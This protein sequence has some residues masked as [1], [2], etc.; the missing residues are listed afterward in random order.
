MKNNYKFIL[1]ITSLTAGSILL[2]QAFWVY[3]TYQTSEVNFRAEVNAAL[4]RSVDI[5]LL[6]SISTPLSL[7]G[8]TPSLSIINTVSAQNL[9][10]ATTASKTN[11]IKSS[12]PVRMSLNALK[13]DRANLESVRL[14]LAKTIALSNKDS[15]K[16]SEIES[17]FKK[18]LSKEKIKV[19]YQLS[20][21]RFSGKK[22]KYTIAAYLGQ[23]KGDWVIEAQLT[24]TRGYLLSQNAVPAIIS[25]FLILITAGSLWY[26]GLII[27]RQKQLDVK[28][29]DFINNLTHELRTPISI[30]KSTNEALL[31]FGES[32]N[33]EK[34][35]R[36]LKINAG[37]LNKLDADLDRLLN[38]SKY[39]LGARTAVIT[40]VNIPDLIHEVIEKFQLND[41]TTITVESELNIDVIATDKHMIE[42]IITNLLDNALKYNNLPAHIIIKASALTRA[43]QLEVEDNGQGIS[44]E[45]LS[46]IFD[47]F[48]R[49]S[50]GDLH[51]VKGY[52]IGLSYV[53]Q[54]VT[55]LSGEINVSSRVG[56]GTKF[57]IKFPL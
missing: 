9:G 17:L 24:N 51:E 47:K 10:V 38:I 15:I 49:V 19:D 36:Y 46:L 31:Q 34:T 53:K 21:H 20:L 54:L 6:E 25:L 3:K 28:K 55:T 45:N 35:T 7:S 30:L 13:I 14:F 57:I 48:Y 26:M 2:F 44:E 32:K 52:G 18:E 56:A 42:S 4:Q 29:N 41:N 1:W 37:V 39:E 22:S 40:P 12:G 11:P 5:Y 50:T 27:R 8:E 43:W 33:V 23:G 16:L